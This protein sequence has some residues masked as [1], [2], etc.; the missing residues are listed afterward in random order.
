MAGELFLQIRNVYVAILDFSY[1]V[2]K[3]IKAGRL[4]KIRHA[5]KEIV[6]AELPEFPGKMHAI[7]RLKVNSLESSQGDFQEE[8]FAKLEDVSDDLSNVKGTLLFLSKAVQSSLQFSQGMQQM[9]TEIS[10]SM[11]VKSHYDLALRYFEMNK[12]AFNPW[13]DSRAALQAHSQRGIGTCIWVSDVPEYV[14]WGDASCSGRLR[15]QGKSGAGKSTLAA[16]IIQTLESQLAE[17]PEYSVQYGF[18]ENKS[19]EHFDAS[20]GIT[21]LESTLVY[22]LYELAVRS[23]ADFVML[24]KCN[25][26]F[27]NP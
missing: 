13:P 10:K 15:I 24:Q 18:C 12:E 25:D 2:R 17:S 21:R 26:V 9:M 3:H 8:T 5:I 23:V 16:Y 27:V 14:A 7:Q 19:G 20:H 22:Q 4:A 6:G 11:R 1:S